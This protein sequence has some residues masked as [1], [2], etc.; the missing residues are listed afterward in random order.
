MCPKVC[1]TRR[2]TVASRHR[3]VRH[4]SQWVE[5][6]HD[7]RQCALQHMCPWNH[8]STSAHREAGVH[9]RSLCV[10]PVGYQQY[11]SSC[12]QSCLATAISPRSKTT[13]AERVLSATALCAP[14]VREEGAR[15]PAGTNAVQQL[16]RDVQRR[17]VRVLRKHDV[18]VARRRVRDSRR[19]FRVQLL[20]DALSAARTS[21]R[22]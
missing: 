17:L 10:W 7:Q 14:I 9:H 20:A 12:T 22:A 15:R 5:Q 13:S 16:P 19:D 18:P 3:R 1:N 21:L 2:R 6:C 11:H 4:P 8:H